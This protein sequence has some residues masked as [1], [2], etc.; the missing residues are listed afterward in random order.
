M[1]KGGGGAGMA[2]LESEIMRM[3][4]ELVHSKTTQ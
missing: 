1:M 3:R 4:K 2:A